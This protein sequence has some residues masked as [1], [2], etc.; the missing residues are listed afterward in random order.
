[1]SED[2]SA[3]SGANVDPPDHANAEDDNMNEL[4]TSSDSDEDV[5]RRQNSGN[6]VSSHHPLVSN[7]KCLH[8]IRDH[9]KDCRLNQEKN[10][11]ETSEQKAT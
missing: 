7:F 5:E 1:M 4:T 3:M 11:S 2:D 10:S 6:A 9:E 8:R